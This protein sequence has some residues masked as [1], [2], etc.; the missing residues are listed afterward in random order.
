MW[1]RRRRLVSSVFGSRV[2]G[3]ANGNAGIKGSWLHL[4][5][6]GKQSESE[7]GFRA[8]AFWFSRS[9]CWRWQG[10][11]SGSTKVQI[12]SV[13]ISN[14][15]RILKLGYLGSLGLKAPFPQILLGLAEVAQIV[16][17]AIRN[18]NLQPIPKQ[19]QIIS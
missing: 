2:D 15:Q 12:V 6:H 13:G 10:C 5:W 19:S 18:R 11:R 14:F 4:A 17:S 16:T 1:S 3:G 9:S 8:G 7:Q